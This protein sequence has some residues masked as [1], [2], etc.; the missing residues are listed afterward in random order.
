MTKVIDDVACGKTL[1]WDITRR[2]CVFSPN[3]NRSGNAMEEMTNTKLI[4]PLNGTYSWLLWAPG[5]I[6][7]GQKSIKSPQ[8]AFVFLYCRWMNKG[9]QSQHHSKCIRRKLSGFFPLNEEKRSIETVSDVV[10]VAPLCVGNELWY[11]SSVRQC[12]LRV[13]V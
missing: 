1:W 2:T 12:Y 8:M 4:K 11:S 3:R 13:P 7:W 5:E 9:T 10:G 6:Y